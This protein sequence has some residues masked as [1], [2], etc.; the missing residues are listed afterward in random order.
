M[1]V[2]TGAM[3]PSSSAFTNQLLLTNIARNI[4]ATSG[5]LTATS[6]NT[7]NGLFNNFVSASAISG[8]SATA[9]FNAINAYVNYGSSAQL[10][11]TQILGASSCID[12]MNLQSKSGF[13]VSS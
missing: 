9:L 13:Q 6:A 3:I 4:I 2:L 12:S 8:T 11:V 5:V 10:F 7:L 1:P